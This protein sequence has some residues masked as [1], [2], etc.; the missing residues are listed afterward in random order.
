ML[1]LSTSLVARRGEVF[2]FRRAVPSDLIHSLGNSDIRRSLR[3]SERRIAMKRVWS[4]IGRIETIRELAPQE[5]SGLGLDPG[6]DADRLQVATDI[7]SRPGQ[8]AAQA[9]EMLSVA[10]VTKHVQCQFGIKPAATKGRGDLQIGETLDP[11]RPGSDEAA[12]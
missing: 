3:T 4:L 1:G 11:F 7:L 12:A 2:W 5:H 6:L 8:F 10:A 9:F